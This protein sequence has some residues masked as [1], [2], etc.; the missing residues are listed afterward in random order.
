[1]RLFFKFL[2][3]ALLFYFIQIVV[4]ILT[5]TFLEYFGFLR[6]EDYSANSLIIS[7]VLYIGWIVIY[8]KLTLIWVYLLLFLGLSYLLKKKL[9]Y[10]FINMIAC[11]A[12]GFIIFYYKSSPDIIVI[13]YAPVIIGSVL[14]V[15][16]DM[17]MLRERQHE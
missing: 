2:S 13:F 3:N 14:I 9:R 5:R 12:S 1:M 17:I 10:S 4:E 8:T 16:G 11:L 6:S 15:I 7:V